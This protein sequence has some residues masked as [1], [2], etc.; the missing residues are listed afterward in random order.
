[1]ISPR[2]RGE[3]T[4][5]DEL[6]SGPFWV[7]PR[8][9]APDG[10]LLGWT[11][12]DDYRISAWEPLHMLLLQYVQLAYRFGIVHYRCFTLCEWVNLFC[13]SVI[14]DTTKLAS[15]SLDLSCEGEN[16]MLK[17][18]LHVSIQTTVDGVLEQTW[19]REMIMWSILSNDLYHR[20]PHCLDNISSNLKLS[21][22]VMLESDY[23]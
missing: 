3:Y 16:I 15:F 4:R 1:M 20:L 13:P 10:H 23:K 9:D 2:D 8:F 5:L 14:C 11:V 6:W 22:H 21:V 7:P 19:D 12:L 18:I 17:S